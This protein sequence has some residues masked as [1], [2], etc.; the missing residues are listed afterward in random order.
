M[1]EN[2]KSS[3][4]ISSTP[5]A[6]KSAIVSEVAESVRTNVSAPAPPVSWSAPSLADNRVV[7]VTPVY[8]VDAVAAHDEIIAGITIYGIISAVAEQKVVLVSLRSA[9]VR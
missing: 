1:T 3:S 8:G 7:V 4:A 6:L 9:P 5:L 2:M